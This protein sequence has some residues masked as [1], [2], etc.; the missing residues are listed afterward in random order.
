MV[1]AE[2]DEF[3]TVNV[4]LILFR[5]RKNCD[6]IVA[7][8]YVYRVPDCKNDFLKHPKKSSNFDISFCC[9]CRFIVFN[10]YMKLQMVIM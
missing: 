7:S 4:K 9:L 5:R 1:S 2:S 8:C 6:V 3:L 10:I